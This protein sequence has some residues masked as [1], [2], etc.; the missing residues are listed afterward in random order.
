MKTYHLTDLEIEMEDVKC[1][2]KR[3]FN[4][5]LKNG[6]LI[7]SVEFEL[8]HDKTASYEDRVRVAGINI[9]CKLTD[10]NIFDDG[11]NHPV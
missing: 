2:L 4:L 3:A 10:R 9:D 7:N 5:A 6:V 8:Q 1:L 11:I